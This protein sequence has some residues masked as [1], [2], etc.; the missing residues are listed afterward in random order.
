MVCTGTSLNFKRITEI[1][2]SYEGL[3]YELLDCGNEEKLERFGEVTL[4]RPSRL[5]VWNRTL[6][7]SHWEDADAY[8][9]AK[10]G[11]SF[12]KPERKVL[13]KFDQNELHLRFEKNGQLG[14]FPESY[15]FIKET[16]PLPENIEAPTMLNL[17]AY[18]G[19]A[20]I[21]G[22]RAGY[23]VT[24]VDIS[25]RALTWAKEN[26][27]KCGVATKI[28][29]IAE[30][31]L[32]FIQ[33]EARREKRY[34]CIVL[35]PPSYSHEYEEDGVSHLPTLLYAVSEI[36]EP[37]GHILFTSHQ[38]ELGLATFLN[39]FKQELPFFAPYFAQSLNLKG[40]NRDLFCGF[41]IALKG[42]TP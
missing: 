33:K 18:T 31:A 9:E 11:W 10:K 4:I 41:G 29:L 32:S 35:D 42:E 34:N 13:V 5:S 30:D 27:V 20:S 14:I 1:P 17:F 38:R 6:S 39:L 28:R 16:L 15:G 36:I 7:R 3:S 40:N 8:Y 37:G 19:L 21:M 24:H 25:K 2:L 26:F 23:Q 12:L 22:V